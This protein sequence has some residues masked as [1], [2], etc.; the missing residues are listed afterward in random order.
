M[1]RGMALLGA[2]FLLLVYGIFG[3]DRSGTTTSAAYDIGLVALAV[4]LGLLIRSGWRG[5]SASWF[6]AAAGAFIGTWVLYELLRQGPC[7]T[8]ASGLPLLICDAI[9]FS[10]SAAPQLSAGAALV[11]L[12]VGWL[13][14]R[15]LAGSRAPD[16]I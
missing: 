1:I 7:L 9:P 8:V 13:R 4:S 3:F 5:S 2:A 6:S 11:A 12:V 14:L 15:H 10:A 16:L